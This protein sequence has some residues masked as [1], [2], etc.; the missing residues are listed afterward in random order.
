MVPERDTVF[1]MA[2]PNK[3]LEKRFHLRWVSIK[4]RPPLVEEREE[5]ELVRKWFAYGAIELNE[6]LKARSIE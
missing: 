2:D 1:G 5:F 4:G 3:L 6:I